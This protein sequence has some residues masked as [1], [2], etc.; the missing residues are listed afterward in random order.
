[1]SPGSDYLS[2]FVH[3]LPDRTTPFAGVTPATGD[4]YGLAFIQGFAQ[5]AFAGVPNDLIVSASSA[6]AGL[7]E[8]TT[9]TCDHFS[10]PLDPRI[11][12]VFARL[13]RMATVAGT[14]EVPGTVRRRR[15]RTR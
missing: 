7:P 1:M 14:G 13:S 2:G 8:V 11:Q 10:Y 9:L 5:H 15:H 4:G 12:A 6:S 3:R